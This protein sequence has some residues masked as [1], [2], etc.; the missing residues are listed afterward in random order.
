MSQILNL[1][2]PELEEICKLIG[3]NI[4][5]D[6]LYNCLSDDALLFGKLTKL[7]IAVQNGDILKYWNKTIEEIELNPEEVL[8]DDDEEDEEN[9]SDSLEE[10]ENYNDDKSCQTKSEVEQ[11]GCTSTSGKIVRKAWTK[12]ERRI[13]LEYFKSYIERE[14][15]PGKDDCSKFLALHPQL[16][17]RRNW[18]H[19]KYFI[20]NRIVAINRTLID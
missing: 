15:L 16:F 19:I 17:H 20:H 11:R 13:T 14:K 5:V 8:S 6:T 12:K 18:L 3:H 1:S 10:D 4:Q 7:L 9:D 2:Q